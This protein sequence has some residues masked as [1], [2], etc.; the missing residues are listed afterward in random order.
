LHAH[1]TKLA[2]FARASHSRRVRVRCSG[3]GI[4]IEGE[5]QIGKE[6]DSQFGWL[7]KTLPQP[8]QHQSLDKPPYPETSSWPFS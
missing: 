7:D 3:V 5:V 4:G 2:P 8:N 1:N 6:C